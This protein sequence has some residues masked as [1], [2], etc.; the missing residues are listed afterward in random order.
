M[1]RGLAWAAPLV[2][3]VVA[4]DLA[5]GLLRSVEKWNWND[6]RLARGIA[7]LHG[8]RLY[9]GRDD[10]ASI[11]GT[12]HGPVAYLLYACL[13]FL[14][15]PTMALLAGCG[16]S[17]VLYFGAVLWTICA[18]AGSGASGRLAGAY[19]FLACTVLLLNSA[20]ARF[21]GLTV[22]VDACALCCAMLASGMVAFPGN[23]LSRR[24][25][26]AS[27]ILAMLSVA[28]KQTMAPVAL[29]L[30]CFVLVADGKRAFARYV[31]VQIMS[32]IAI[33][34]AMLALFRPAAD[35]FFNTFTLAISLPRTESVLS[36]GMQGISELRGEL[37]AAAAPLVFL[38]L[39]FLLDAR[40]VREKLVKH[41]WLVFPW[42]ALLQL[43]VELR[44]WTTIGGARNHLGVVT[45]FVVLGTI[46]GL[47]VLWRSERP[48]LRFTAR[49]MIIGILLVY[50]AIPWNL[51]RLLHSIRNNPT[52][53]AYNYDLR[54]PGRVY[55]PLNPL[56]VLLAEGKLRHFEFALLDRELAGFPVSSAQFD[57]GLP[58][59]A[60]LIAYPKREFPRT[61]LL[62]N[63]LRNKTLVTEPGLEGW[64]V[65]RLK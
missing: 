38:L 47:V 43:P 6:P 3:V 2:G 65:Y 7:M 44:A 58:P 50:L 26:I 33:L 59:S 39:V 51:R 60:E 19:G 23:I 5:A 64:K 35:L 49:A 27:A 36:R 15:D 41:R 54:H 52:Q 4:A 48:L 45:L 57:A 25:L 46:S 29:A 11:I 1:D 24:A 9:P 10:Q 14:K 55:F 20:G 21:S 17:C 28:S 30:P 53:V 18:A 62:K 13:A 16:L 31:F 12:L 34:A 56:A 40:G 61:A 42:I 22:H 32:S 63:L 37:A 8:Y